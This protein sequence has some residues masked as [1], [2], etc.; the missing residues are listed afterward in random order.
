[1]GRGYLPRW[2]TYLPGEGYLPSQL[3][4]GV[5]TFPSRGVPTF[6][7]GGAPYWSSIACTCYAA[8]GMP[9]AFTQ[10]DFLVVHV[11]VPGPE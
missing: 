10:E 1:M 4:G 9:L 8:G 11:C 7:G 3:G 6:P 5:P 2:G